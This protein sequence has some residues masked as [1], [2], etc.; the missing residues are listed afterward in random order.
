MSEFLFMLTHDDVTVADAADVY[1]SVRGWHL[2]SLHYL[3]FK[4][5]GLPPA[6][7]RDLCRNMHDDG[8]EVMLE[9]VS[10]NSEDELRSLAAS[11]HIGVDYVLG[12]ANADAGVRILSGGPR[13]FPFPGTVVGHPSRLRGSIRD[14]A[15]HAAQLCAVDG[16]DGLDLLAYRYD[17]NAEELLATV[18]AAVDRP[19]IAAG[20][21]NS[22]ERIRA[23]SR[24]GA[25]AFTM[26][27]A[28]FERTLRP[29]GS[30]RDQVEFA[31]G[32]GEQMTTERA[33][34][35]AAGAGG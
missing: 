9:V 2:N 33:G 32:L 7:L 17:G 16:I 28:V 13:Y 34:S 29:G 19:V 26:G 35:D 27:S 31:L 20:S 15:S 22:E 18:V 3:G 6:A 11:T 23:V 5:V 21:I 12:G 4:D 14:V 24:G 25:W 1:R 8:F 10:E 30:L